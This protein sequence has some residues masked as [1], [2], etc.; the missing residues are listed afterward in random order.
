MSDEQLKQLT[1]AEAAHIAVDG[2]VF[3]VPREHATAVIQAIPGARF[4]FEH[5]GGKHVGTYA[6]GLDPE[7]VKSIGG[8]NERRVFLPPSAP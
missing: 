8:V 2:K 4:S 6:R 7:W 5:L 1:D 3:Q